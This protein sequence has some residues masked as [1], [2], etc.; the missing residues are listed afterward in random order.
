MKVVFERNIAEGYC[1]SGLSCGVPSCFILTK[2]LGRDTASNPSLGLATRLATSSHN[3]K[4]QRRSGRPTKQADDRSRSFLLLEDPDYVRGPSAEF[5]GRTRVVALHGLGSSIP[6]RSSIP[7]DGCWRKCACVCIG[8]DAARAASSPHAQMGNGRGRW[9]RVRL[10][11]VSAQYRRGVQAKP[12]A[13]FVC[14]A[15]RGGRA[16]TTRSSRVWQSAAGWALAPAPPAPRAG[17]AEL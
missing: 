8:E 4:G 14:R 2:N 6:R 7:R 16:V 10:L 11:S 13:L 9:S 17:R 1:R 12:L 3:R 5:F 15:V